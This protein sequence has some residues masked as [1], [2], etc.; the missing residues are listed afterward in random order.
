MARSKKNQQQSSKQ[1]ST[2]P[3]GSKRLFQ[4][5][6]WYLVAAGTLLLLGVIYLDQFF[7]VPGKRLQAYLYIKSQWLLIDELFIELVKSWYGSDV[8]SLGFF[9]RA[10]VFAVAFW[11][12]L[13][14]T[15]IGWLIL[16]SRLRERLDWLEQFVFSAGIGLNIVSLYTLAVGW[17]GG[18]MVWGL[19]IIPMA[20]AVIAASAKLII[21]G[22]RRQSLPSSPPPV[23]P[24]A[25]RWWWAAIVPFA[26]WF[27]LAAAV[28]PFDF[29]VREYH[30]QIPKEWFLQGFIDFVP[31]NVYG[32][33]PLGAEMQALTAMVLMPQAPSWWFGALAGKVVISGFALLSAVSLFA[34]CRRFFLSP[35]AGFVAA[36]V[37]LSTHWILYVSTSGLIEG[38][39]GTYL[40]LAVHAVLLYMRDQGLLDG[41]NSEAVEPSSPLTSYVAMAGFFAGAAAAC[42]YPA[43]IFVVVPVAIVVALVSGKYVLRSSIVYC[44]LVLAGCGLWYVKNAVVAQNPTYPLLYSVFGGRG[45]DDK[46]DQRWHAAHQI[47]KEEGYRLRFLGTNAYKVGLASEQLSPLLVPLGLLSMLVKRN[48][49]VVWLVM[50]MIVFYFL[51]WWF[52]THRLERF[53]APALFLL[54]LLAGIGYL[55]LIENRRAALVVWGLFGLYLLKNLVQSHQDILYIGVAGALLAA[56]VAMGFYCWKNER[57]WGYLV[58]SLLALSLVL[59][60]II[61]SEGALGI[62]RRVFMALEKFRHDP[63]R[64]S[65]PQLYLN[66]NVEPGE[67]VLAVGD[68]AV[69]DLEMHT[70]YDT[71]WNPS[72]FE[73]WMKDRT[74]QER[75]DELEAH[76]VSYVY[77]NWNE[78]ARY[79]SPGNYGYS[80]YVTEDLVRREMVLKDG[81]FETIPIQMGDTI[82]DPSH[83]EVLKVR[84]PGE[85]R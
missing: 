20:L 52:F 38:V 37:L 26:I 54:A 67:S 75:L 61:N 40:L 42:K 12:F 16:P 47:P 68:A 27:P 33:M 10:P 72:T 7:K 45:W 74:P 48:R 30:L 63:L 31:H 84:Y 5:S 49:R 34:I 36:I 51:A 81:I 17:A 59:T 85:N 73:L 18:L 43:L 82:M 60:F 44:L 25:S 3:E 24:K 19:W 15:A 55:A 77:V 13:S 8:R 6:T 62:D 65:P 46:T 11:I 32:N 22:F 80:D 41:Q 1:K 71:C 50:S 39:V 23:T 35:A 70:Y 58:S 28:P 21:G 2:S 4:P 14:A 64:L 9:D 78:I 57:T 69:F 29:D 66:E 79:R 56:G 83:A 76:N 53:F